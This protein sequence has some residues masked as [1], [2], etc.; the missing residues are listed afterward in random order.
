MPDHMI[1]AKDY[2][3]KKLTFPV[4]VSEKLDGVACRMVKLGQ[5]HGWVGTSRQ[6]K[7]I[8]S[9]HHIREALDKVA[10]NVKC[11]T[12]LIGE[13]T[14]QGVPDFKDA[15][16]IIRRDVPDD[17][18]VLNV[19]DYV[20]PDMERTF[21]IRISEADIL[22][23]YVEEM[24]GL[25]IVRRCHQYVC[26]DQQ[27]LDAFSTEFFY[28]NP[29]AEGLMIRPA[30]SLYKRG[31][32]WDFQRL[33]PK[34]KETIDLWVTGYEEA[35]SVAGVGL[36]RVGRVVVAY[37]DL[38]PGVGPGK[39]THAEAAAEWDAYVAAGDKW[40]PKMAEI[41]YMK[42]DSYNALRQPTFQRWRPD[43]NTP[44]A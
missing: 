33:K 24:V 35:K 38:T 26:K 30:A 41:Q 17:R 10:P 37:K 29:D 23:S 28:G 2:N 22:C 40:Q 9:V 16:G 32:S 36:G 14:V 11:G 6:D 19:Y 4:L 31:R 15:G 8:A 34:G 39:M 20:V 7:N 5:Q 12:E 1:L 13:L 21:K 42:D 18:I 43:K 25:N 27:H 44:D 3:P